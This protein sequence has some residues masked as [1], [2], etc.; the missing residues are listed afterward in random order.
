MQNE[1]KVDDNDV[2]YKDVVIIGKYE[3]SP[4]ASSPTRERLRRFLNQRIRESVT[5][6]R[7]TN[8]TPHAANVE[9]V[10]IFTFEIWSFSTESFM[11]CIYDDFTVLETVE[12]LILRGSLEL[13]YCLDSSL[14]RIVGDKI[15]GLMTGW[16]QTCLTTSL[17]TLRMSKTY[18]SP[19]LWLDP[20]YFFSLNF[21]ARI[22]QGWTIITITLNICGKWQYFIND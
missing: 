20:R 5:E 19:Y 17:F 15:R 7:Q 3:I 8:V 2:I 13:I 9:D 14:P 22:I 11:R 1:Y 4:R 12:L 10:F 6:W 18:L 21:F 16:Q